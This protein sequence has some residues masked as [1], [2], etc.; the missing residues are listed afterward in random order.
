MDLRERLLRVGSS[1]PDVSEP[2]RPAHDAPLEALLDGY[3]A[4]VAGAR[5]FIVEHS[6]P[7]AHIHGGQAFDQACIAPSEAWSPF[8]GEEACARF[9]ARRAALLDI[10]TTGLSRGAGTFAFMVGIGLFDADRLTVRQYFAPDY[11]DENA[12]LDLLARDLELSACLVTFNGRSFDWPILET[13]YALARRAPPI[14]EDAPHLDLLAVARALWR[15]QLTSCALGALELHA[16]GIRR[17]LQDTPGYLIP[18]IYQDYLRWGDTLPLIGVFYHNQM[19]ILA[20]ASL[21]ARAGRILSAPFERQDDPLCDY[22][23]LGALYE[24]RGRTEEA[25]QAYRLAASRASNPDDVSLACQRLAALLKRH[26]DYPGA[27][28]IW[29]AQTGGAA[30]YPYIELAKHLEHRARDYAEARRTILDAMVWLQEHDRV[31]QRAEFRRIKG[32]LER[33]LARVERRLAQS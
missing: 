19:D 31:L 7:L 2:D 27:V 21:M 18:Q 20:M 10:E 5:C 16:L 32:D 25:M 29:R 6:Y 33:R 9:D 11:G 13:R 30:V 28:E 22:L 26:G 8:L 23:A 4:H 15:R 3:W 17:E 1:R 14:D 12:L 24:R